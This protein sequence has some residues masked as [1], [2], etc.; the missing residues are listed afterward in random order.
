MGKPGGLE[1]VLGW[2]C[3]FFGVPSVLWSERVVVCFSAS[4][5]CNLRT[6][7]LSCIGVGV[8]RKP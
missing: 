4:C 1:G 3:G 5:G 8:A 7:I 6:W 2:V